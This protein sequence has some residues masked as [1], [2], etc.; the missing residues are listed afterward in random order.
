MLPKGGLLEQAKK[1]EAC[2]RTA[3]KGL[4]E[5]QPAL[6]ELRDVI[7]SGIPDIRVGFAGIAGT[8]TLDPSL[9]QKFIG[10][11][12]TTQSDMLAALTRLNVLA[13]TQP[14]ASC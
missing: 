12:S 8:T 1:T 10:I 5:A 14:N 11:D 3:S 13:I 2:I 9:A 7:N 6:H 4:Q